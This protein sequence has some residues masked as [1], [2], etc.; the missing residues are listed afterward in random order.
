IIKKWEEFIISEINLK[1]KVNLSETFFKI[2]KEEKSDQIAVTV[3]FNLVEY[4]Y[5]NPKK[6][7]LDIGDKSLINDKEFNNITLWKISIMKL[8]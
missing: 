7:K 8:Q 3:F 4:V 1:E 2:L 6:L 5:N